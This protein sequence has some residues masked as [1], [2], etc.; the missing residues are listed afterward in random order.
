MVPEFLF[1]Y[2][3]GHKF[4][5]VIIGHGPDQFDLVSFTVF[6]PQ[7]L[8]YLALVVANHLVGHIQDL[9]GAPVVL[10]QLDDLHIVIILSEQEYVFNGRATECIDRLCIISHHTDILVHGTQ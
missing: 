2:G 7:L 6:R 8:W 10:F 5:F 3:V 1:L 9:F 4:S